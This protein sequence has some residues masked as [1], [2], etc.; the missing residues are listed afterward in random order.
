MPKRQATGRGLFYTRDSGGAHETTPGEYV[1]WAQR[2]AKKLGVAFDGT[3]DGIEAMIRERLSQSGDL[4]L[5]YG[6][7]GN[8]LQRRGLDALFHV[9]QSDLGVT[10]VFIPRRDRFARPVDPSDA[11]KM[12]NTLRQA[13][14]T[15]VFM[16]KILRPLRRGERDVGEAIT[17]YC[18]YDGAGKFCPD[19][20]RKIILSQLKLAKSGFSTGGRPPYGFRR[21]F[22]REDGTPLRELAEGEYARMAGHHVVWL[23]GPDAELN[24]IRRILGMLE[25]TPASR[26]AATLTAEGVPTPDAGRLRTDNEITHLTSGA[27]HQQTVVNIARNPLLRAVVEYGRRSMGEHWRFSLEGPREL[28]EADQLA[29]G[30]PKTVVNDAA[31]RIRAPARFEPLVESERHERL[32]AK[33]DG[34]AGTQQG[35]PRSR[36]PAGNP[37]GGLVFDMNCAWLMYRQPYRGSF[38]YLCGLYQQSHG[39]KCK[40]NCVDGVVATQFL[41]GCVRQQ[42]LAP[43]IRARLEQKLRAIAARECDHTRPKLE[44]AK[45]QAA[46]AAAKANRERAGRNLALADGPDQYREVAAV[47]EQLKGQEAALE[48]EIRLLEQAADT[49]LDPE[50]EVAAAM[51][52]VDRLAELADSPAGLEGAGRLFQQL[53]ARLFLRFTEGLWKTRVVTK[54]AGGVVTFGSTPPPLTLYEGPTGRRH[55]KGPADPDGSAGPG[56]N[57]SPGGPST[58]PGKEGDSLGKVNRG[59]RI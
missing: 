57:D 35:K 58:V 22:V 44:L 56:S 34:R 31:V 46:L 12:E 38:R 26:V 23:P 19:L 30:D 11:M 49:R 59:E 7:K 45:K 4:F 29:N 8:R 48:A 33:L 16:D 47:F 6:V 50:A 3:P 2:E 25:T 28:D 51:A 27:W 17:G 21:W 5:D 37:L 13:G 42:L 18:E 36:N 32:L 43:T 24:I 41:L 39:A 40:H 15:L 10:H 53:N 52:G 54:V 55:V 20:A 1:L 9:A 14:L